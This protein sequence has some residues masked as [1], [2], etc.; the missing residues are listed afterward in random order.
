[1]SE[2]ETILLSDKEIFPTD[3][4]IFSIIG[5][6]KILWQSIM[7]YM[8]SNYKDSSGEWN[9]YKDGKR[10]LFKMVLKKKTIFWAAVL[11]DTFRITFYFGNKAEP[12]IEASDL[13]QIMKDEFR[14]AKRYGLI[15]PVSFKILNK[16]DVENVQKLIAIKL[17]IK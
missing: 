2:K 15:R 4:Y 13:P 3:E 16:T 6:K 7:D 1:M 5:E 17:K 12:F 10:W 9:Y 14:T 11:A 8:I